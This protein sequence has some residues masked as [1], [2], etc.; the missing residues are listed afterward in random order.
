MLV[1]LGLCA[2]FL[3]GGGAGFLGRELAEVALM[4]P[5][6]TLVLSRD[7]PLDFL[8]TDGSCSDRPAGGLLAGSRVIV[9]SHGAVKYVQMKFSYVGEML[10]SSQ[11]PFEPPEGFQRG[12]CIEGR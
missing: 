2:A 1:F 5:A 9:R 8:K 10:P 4:G 6:E 7:L 11:E 3:L 12:V